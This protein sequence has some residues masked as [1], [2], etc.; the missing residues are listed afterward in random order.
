[1]S[2][3]ILIIDDNQDVR[4]VLMEALTEEGGYTTHTAKDL[5]AAR[6]LMAKL[7]ESLNLVLLDVQLP[8]GNGI[9]FCASL[10]RQGNDLPIIV[11]SGYA[12]ETD[13]ERAFAA[14]ASDYLIKP[15]PISILLA[16][17]SLQ[18]RHGCSKRIRRVVPSNRLMSLPR[19][20]QIQ[21]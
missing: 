1:M 19:A 5:G 2:S 6:V 3:S 14:G 7:G 21:T 13:V 15:T 20:I 12:S 9:S 8:D 4:D 10:R 17:V 11:L 18:L 16:R